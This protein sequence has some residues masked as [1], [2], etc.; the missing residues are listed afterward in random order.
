MAENLRKDNLI[1]EVLRV[2]VQPF[3]REIM[4][5]TWLIFVATRHSIPPGQSSVTQVRADVSPKDLPGFCVTCKWNISVDLKALPNT[6]STEILP[7]KT[8]IERALEKEKDTC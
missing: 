3:R 5:C 2:T 4:P 1:A 8:E 6:N 7:M